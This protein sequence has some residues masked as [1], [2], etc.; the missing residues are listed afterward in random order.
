M[1]LDLKVIDDGI[2]KVLCELVFSL[3]NNMIHLTKVA[4]LEA[5]VPQIIDLG[6][7]VRSTA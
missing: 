5:V 4:I 7:A 1:P 6:F 2:N 3:K